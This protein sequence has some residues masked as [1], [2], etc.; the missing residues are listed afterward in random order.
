MTK[1]HDARFKVGSKRTPAFQC[2][3]DPGY[4]IIAV[5]H[6]GH[7]C[8]LPFTGLGINSYLLIFIDSLREFLN[9]ISQYPRNPFERKIPQHPG[10]AGGRER[11]ARGGVKAPPSLPERVSTSLDTNGFLRAIFTAPRTASAATAL[12]AAVPPEIH[13]HAPR[14]RSR[15]NRRHRRNRWSSTAA[16]GRDHRRGSLLACGQTRRGW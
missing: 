5:F 13:Q 6:Q 14:S 7:G 2:H 4:A 15:Q 1:S 8:P 10:L 12:P 16:S 3:A 9:R 11:T